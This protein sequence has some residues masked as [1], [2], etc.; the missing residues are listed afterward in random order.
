MSDEQII[1]VQA[2]EQKENGEGEAPVAAVQ[3][4]QQQQAAREV[5]NMA[6]IDD[7]FNLWKYLCKIRKNSVH[8]A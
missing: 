8:K 5:H 2:E 3:L 4:D 1:D 6:W 7:T